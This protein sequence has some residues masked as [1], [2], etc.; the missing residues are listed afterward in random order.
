MI[1]GVKNVKEKKI[2]ENLLDAKINKLLDE[3]KKIDYTSDS[4]KFFNTQLKKQKEKIIQVQIT[5][6]TKEADE[7]INNNTKKINDLKTMK[8]KELDKLYEK[9]SKNI[10]NLIEEIR[11]SLNPSSSTH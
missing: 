11:V 3:E 2:L 1:E 5:E 4:G 6:I 7:E 9:T 10:T 8:Y